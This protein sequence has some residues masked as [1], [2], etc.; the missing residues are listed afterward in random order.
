MTTIKARV[1]PSHRFPGPQGLAL[2]QPHRLQLQPLATNS[3]KHFCCPGACYA[4]HPTYALLWS[5]IDPFSAQLPPPPSSISA[6]L[7][8]SSLLGAI[9]HQPGKSFK[10]KTNY[11]SADVTS[12]FQPPKCRAKY[13]APWLRIF[14]LH[15]DGLFVSAFV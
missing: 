5:P 7:I 11:W 8:L 6:R 12:H 2:G 10:N 3:T 4:I 14:L 1:R 15:R 9:N 13:V